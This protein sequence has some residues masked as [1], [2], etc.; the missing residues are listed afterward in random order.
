MV[1]ELSHAAVWEE[2][3]QDVT[4]DLI[5]ERALSYCKLEI[6]ESEAA[7]SQRVDLE[8]CFVFAFSIYFGDNILARRSEKAALALNVPNQS[9]KVIREIIL[10]L[11]Y[12]T[13]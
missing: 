6:K 5:A 12:L 3:K 7:H 9:W 2:H 13:Y 11:F 10:D 1:R 4:S 8:S